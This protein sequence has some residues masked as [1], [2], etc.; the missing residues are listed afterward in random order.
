LRKYY[1]GL[2]DKQQIDPQNNLADG[3]SEVMCPP[4]QVVMSRRWLKKPDFETSLTLSEVIYRCPQCRS[5]T[6]RWIEN[7]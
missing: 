4:C 7:L 2:R 1:F 3:T 6:N 5:T